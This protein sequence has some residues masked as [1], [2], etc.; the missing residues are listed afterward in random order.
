MNINRLPDTVSEFCRA[1]SYPRDLADN[2][3][4][5]HDRYAWVG[6]LGEPQLPHA[7]EPGCYVFADA[8]GNILYVG[9]SSR[10][11]GMG[12]RI[13]EKWGRQARTGEAVPFPDA[14]AWV[15]P[16]VSVRAVAVPR[17]HWFLAPALEAFLIDRLGPSMNCLTC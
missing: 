5:P 14:K 4:G 16:G 15:M 17:D 12:D 8:Q 7:D 9:K 6:K 13:W 2:I 10:R 1:I 3:K 11:E